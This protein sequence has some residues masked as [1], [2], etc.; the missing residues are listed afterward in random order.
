MTPP[1]NPHNLVTK[2]TDKRPR[3]RVSAEEAQAAVYS[4]LLAYGMEDEPAAIIA[5]HLADANLCGV[6]SHGIMRI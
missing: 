5:A 4:I 3:V 1:S 2:L 6:E